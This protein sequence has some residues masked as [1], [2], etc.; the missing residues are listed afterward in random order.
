MSYIQLYTKSL[1]PSQLN[2]PILADE[3]GIPRYWATVWA[4]ITDKDLAESTQMKRLRH[5]E[6]LYRF[7]D[8]LHG[9]GF[10]DDALGEI[11]IEEIGSI[12]EAY[13]MRLKNRSALTNTSEQQWQSGLSF[14][15]GVILRLS[16]SGKAIAKLSE[17]ES[18]MLRFNALYGQ[19][20]VKKSN[21]P[22]ILRS[23]PASVVSY[24]YDILDPESPSN[25][26]TRTRTKWVV[27]QA[28]ILMLHQGLRVGEVLLLPVNALNS[29]FDERLL[30][31]R[32]W[33]NIK[34]DEDMAM[35]DSRQKRPSI[36]TVD[37]NRQ[38]PVSELT[39]RI[40]QT[41]TDNYRGKP[42]HPFLL[43][44]QWNTALSHDSVTT[45]AR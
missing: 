8:E 14:V 45:A 25:P 22:E 32:Y 43:N 3:S 33:I 35:D 26:F 18:R 7:C 19:L 12:L 40:I 9:E 17:I 16:K 5:I 44:S 37:S 42:N 20:H 29:S 34:K 24:L 30:R 10:L 23:L 36:K 41:Y 2:S 13:F 39:S 28:F 1:V 21:R 27:Y 6:S 4:A 15:K 31:Q 11:R 38:V